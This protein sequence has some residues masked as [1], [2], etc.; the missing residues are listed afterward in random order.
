MGKILKDDKGFSVVELFLVL[1][2][3]ALVGALGWFVYKDHNKATVTTNSTTSTQQTTTAQAVSPYK[4]WKSYTL[5]NAVSFKYPSTWSIT[6]G[7]DP[8]EA[9]ELQ[10]IEFTTPSGQTVTIQLANSSASP[11]ETYLLQAEPIT[12][13]GN[14]AHLDYESA[15][16]S[17]SSVGGII[18]SPS[19]TNPT[20]NGPISTTS[21]K[22]AGQP[23]DYLDAFLDFRQDSTGEPI[24]STANAV[25]AS[26]D[27]A[28][29]KLMVE[30]VTAI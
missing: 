5:G 26:S 17:E 22:I 18:L 28:Q 10:A 2:I 1:I 9:N 3:V 8:T 13:L 4:G 30:S 23:Y 20:S 27:Y 11:P 6:N 19:P 29:F 25:K 15:T 16:N 12:V 14:H 7:P 24:T 21:I